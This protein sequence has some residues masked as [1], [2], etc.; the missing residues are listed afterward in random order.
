VPVSDLQMDVLKALVTLQG[1]KYGRLID[2]MV[3]IEGPEVNRRHSILL[4]A[5]MFEATEKRFFRNGKVAP[6]SEI[7]SFVAEVRSRNDRAAEEL[8]P[9]LAERVLLGALGEDDIEDLDGETFIMMETM[10]VAVL[11]ADEEYTEEELDAFL[12]LVRRTADDWLEE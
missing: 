7:I 8:H 2:E 4:G 11:V 1:E 3:E 6:K 5:A 10:L 12:R 9:T